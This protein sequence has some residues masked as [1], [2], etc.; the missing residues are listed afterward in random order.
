MTTPNHELDT[1]W[2]RHFPEFNPNPVMELNLGSKE[3]T[4]T[5]SAAKEMFSELE[6]RVSADLS[7]RFL[8][9]FQN[10]GNSDLHQIEIVLNN[11]SYDVKIKHHPEY[12]A[13]RIYMA[14]MTLIRE[15]EGKLL[16][17]KML[18]ELTAK[19]KSTFIANMS[20]EIRTPINGMV[21][22]AQLLSEENLSETQKELVKM[23]YD[24]GENLTAITNDVLDLS[25]LEAN[26]MQLEYISV[27]LKEI[28][29]SLVKILKI[30]ASNKNIELRFHP[31]AENLQR[32]QCDPT[33]I[34]QILS[35]ILNNAIKF[36]EKGSIEL[37]INSERLGE[38]LHEIRFEIVDTG[39]GID[40]NKLKSVFEN[41]FQADQS[42][43]RK[44]GGTGLGMAISKELAQ[45]MEGDINIESVL[46]K[47]TTVSV[48][49]PM[50]VSEHAV[51]SNS[52]LNKSRS[53]N[54]G[55]RV[56]LA[57][58]VK[59][60]AILAEKMLSGLG[61]T[62]D[63]CCNG[64]EVLETYDDDYDLILMDMRM[65]EIDGLEASRILV[66]KGCNT[67]IVALTANVSESDKELCHKSGMSGFL[68]KPLFMDALVKELDRFIGPAN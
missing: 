68:T 7:Q 30:P 39:I 40:E 49:I 45:L 5:N 36:T 48:T 32:Y 50:K 31:P 57:E 61:L 62:V 41:F 9:E 28:A 8:E 37:S 19:R 16:K 11:R 46:G 67:P 2:W 14:D 21:C 17:A 33:R 66:N 35:N 26:K 24:C 56:L 22:A 10:A 23:I 38:D 4:F 15:A 27:D 3:F 55:K 63:V 58:D 52:N 29:E 25:K 53:R 18:A 65:P 13:I 1:N 12:E 20:H 34:R 43:T 59:V 64:K 6:S 54:Y 47:G 60:N 44:Y 51:I 42:T